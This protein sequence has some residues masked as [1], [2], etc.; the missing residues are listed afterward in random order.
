MITSQHKCVLH[1]RLYVSTLPRV[2]VKTRAHKARRRV[3]HLTFRDRR[4]ERLVAT[5]TVHKARRV[6]GVAQLLGRVGDAPEQ[7]L[8]RHHAHGPHV[9]CLASAAGTRLGRH[10]QRRASD[11]ALRQRRL[12]G[13][14]EVRQL[15][16]PV[17][18]Q[19]HV[20]R[21]D[22]AVHNVVVVKVREAVQN[23]L[24]IAPARALGDAPERLQNALQ[25][26]AAH[27]LR[28]DDE[29]GV[30]HGAAQVRHDVVVAEL[31]KDLDLTEDI[32]DV[33]FLGLRRRTWQCVV[34]LPLWDLAALDGDQR[35]V[36]SHS[37]VHRRGGALPQQLLAFVVVH[38]V[39]NE[40][41]ARRA[42][43]GHG[44]ALPPT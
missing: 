6:E 16:L 25:T 17:D 34:D 21:F 31:R 13:G 5:E 9:R 40:T 32:V 39:D 19:Q 1:Q 38:I 4:H 36:I 29:L 15:A 37:E 42:H 12:H 20:V 44:R 8:Q 18:L 23:V 26:A 7:Q 30:D 14:A 33:V 28:H 43:Q 27:E 10:V 24:Q 41:V 35:A 11:V 22:V 3:A 2:A